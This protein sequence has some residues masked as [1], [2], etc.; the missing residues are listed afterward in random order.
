MN[1]SNEMCLIYWHKPLD[2][3]LECP[4]VS[5]SPAENYYHRAHNHLESASVFSF[6]FVCVKFN[7]LNTIFIAHRPKKYQMF[8]ISVLFLPWGSLVSS[9][10]HSWCEPWAL[11][12]NLPH[13]TSAGGSNP[14]NS[15]KCTG[16]VWHCDNFSWKYIFVIVM[17]GE[18]ARALLASC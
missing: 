13:N 14:L 9:D 12:V 5:D 17:F 4:G 15:F 16:W 10:A 11:S 8:C 3:F 7:H 2:F 1:V 18:S 6:F